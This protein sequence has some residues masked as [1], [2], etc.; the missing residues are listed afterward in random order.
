MRQRLDP[1]THHLTGAKSTN[2]T[3]TQL[4]WLPWWLSGKESPS[5]AEDAGYIRGSGRSRGEGNGKTPV[6]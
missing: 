6:F 5:N 1:I 2:S 4:R 3:N